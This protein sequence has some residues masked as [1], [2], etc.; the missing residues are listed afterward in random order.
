MNI[1]FIWSSCSRHPT[2]RSQVLPS[3][4]KGGL[5]DPRDLTAFF[6]KHLERDMRDLAGLTGK[7]FEEA[8]FLLHLV[9]KSLM[10]TAGEPCE[11]TLNTYSIVLQC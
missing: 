4:V 11:Y 6:Y 7:N 1:S 8:T 10:Q 9:I 3:L 2:D 5:E